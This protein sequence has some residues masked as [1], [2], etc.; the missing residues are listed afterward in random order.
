MNDAA[1]VAAIGRGDEAAMNHVME[2]YFKLVWSI[3]SAVLRHTAPVQDVEECVADVFVYLWQNTGKYDARRGTL[4]TWLCVVARSRA[5]NRYHQITRRDDLPMDD[6][7]L[8][9]QLDVSDGIL[10]GE[11]R[12]MLASAVR[13]LDEPDREIVVRRYYYDQAPRDIALALDLPKKQIENR[14][15]R[16]KRKLRALIIQTETEVQP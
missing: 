6:A 15:Y 16:A 2:K 4:K 13:S 1:A 8:A 3:A 11:S 14:L 10:A 7:V 5:I 9:A 12:C